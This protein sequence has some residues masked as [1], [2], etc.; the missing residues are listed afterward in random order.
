M[1]F[2]SFISSKKPGKG[3]YIFVWFAAWVPANIVVYLV[4][5]I[6]AES[7]IKSI[8]DW[9]TYAIIAFPIESIVYLVIG[10]F[11]YK[12]FQNIKISKVMPYI[13]I[14][15]G[16]NFGSLYYDTNLIL[17]SLGVGTTVN[18]FMI[19]ITYLGLCF[20]FRQYFKNSRQW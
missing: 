6:L 17:E 4:D 1:S 15:G 12:K 9:N 7:I 11:V 3:L 19:L 20:G 16:I 13:W 14:L 5:T 18:T 8:D 10:I 2:N